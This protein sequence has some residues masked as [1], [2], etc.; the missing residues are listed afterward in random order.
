MLIY[1]YQY[2][3]IL[4]FENTRRYK[5]NCVFSFIELRTHY[6]TSEHIVFKLPQHRELSIRSFV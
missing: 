5:Y 2:I 3:Y 4:V 1:H 6:V